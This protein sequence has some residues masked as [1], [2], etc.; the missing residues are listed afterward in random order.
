MKIEHYLSNIQTDSDLFLK[1][2]TESV[3]WLAK[4]YARAAQALNAGD[5]SSDEKK[6][7]KL[8]DRI[9]RATQNIQYRGHYLSDY[10]HTNWDQM[11]I[12][13]Q[14]AG[15]SHSDRLKFFTET[16]KSACDRLRLNEKADAFFHVTCTGYVS[17]SP[18]QIWMSE[19]KVYRS[20]LHH[21]YHMGC[22]A[23]LPA[24]KMA[25][26][27]L[28]N[29]KKSARVQIVHSEL[30]TL[31]LNPNN[32]TL[33]DIVI[34][35]LFAD[36]IVAYEVFSDQ[37]Q[38][39]A[40]KLVESFEYLIPDSLDAMTWKVAEFGMAM[41]LSQDVPSLVAKHLREVLTKITDKHSLNLSDREIIWAV[42]PGGPK[43]LDLIQNEFQI[44]TSQMSES[45]ATLQER[46]NMSSATLPFIWKR[47]LENPARRHGQY[48]MSLAF[49]PG[50]TICGQIFQVE[51]DKS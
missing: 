6:F 14:P 11:K 15:R 50:L 10:T 40:L 25:S 30:C 21:I 7:L 20:Q 5:I 22:Y 39:A 32:V 33:E 4:C 43:I 24:V 1:S 17:P 27:V 16:V 2:Q 9:G 12:F 19:N 34:H 51:K 36:G 47:L 48:V 29:E 3:Q 46:G 28:A 8:I 38:G 23:A 35:T 42:H 41:S 37:P 49:G 13:D 26:A 31:H 18:L 44:E 45:F